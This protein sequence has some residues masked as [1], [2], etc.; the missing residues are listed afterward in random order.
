MSHRRF[1]VIHSNIDFELDKLVDNLNELYQ[2]Y[3][4][5]TTAMVV[6]ESMC[7]WQGKKVTKKKMLNN[8]YQF[9]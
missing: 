7:P 6:D 2:K 1:K 9:R 5:P 3:W 8:Y 4:V